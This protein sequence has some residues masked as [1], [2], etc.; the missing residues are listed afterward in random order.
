MRKIFDTEF[1]EKFKEWYSNTII[2]INYQP[3]EDI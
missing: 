3:T 1:K 2:K